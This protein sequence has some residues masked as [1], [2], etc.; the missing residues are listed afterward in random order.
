MSA[1]S[2][3]SS[4]PIDPRDRLIFA[5]DLPTSAEALEWVDRL[6]DAVTFHKVGF[7][8]F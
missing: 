8:L 7:Q 6:G 2:L 4:K 3:L 5:L 1:S